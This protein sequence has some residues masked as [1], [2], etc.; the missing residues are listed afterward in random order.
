M[1]DQLRVASVVPT[2]MLPSMKLR[3]LQSSDAST[4]TVSYF[5]IFYETLLYSFSRVKLLLCSP[6]LTP[7]MGDGLGPS[8]LDT[9]KVSVRHWVNS[10]T[11]TVPPS[12][13][14]PAFLMRFVTTTV[15]ILGPV[16]TKLAKSRRS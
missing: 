13:T 8:G 7:Q 1:I 15:L 9:L 4:Y 2:P 6:V 5:F 11:G 10:V 16:M 3:V 14:T 12:P